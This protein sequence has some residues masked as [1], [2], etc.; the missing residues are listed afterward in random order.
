VGAWGTPAGNSISRVDLGPL[1]RLPP[2][3]LNPQ[4]IGIS[5]FP[6]HIDLQWQPAQDDPNG[7]GAAFYNIYRNGAFYINITS[8]NFSDTAV[9]P[10]TS[11]TY[12][13]YVADYH[14]NWSG[15][16][17]TFTV[18]TPPAGAIDPRRAGV[19]PT[20][21]YW[22]AA[23]ENIDMRSGNLNYTA[24]LLKAMGRGGWGVTFALN[25]NSQLWRQDSGGT[26]KLGRDL[27]YGFGWR[28]QAGSITPFWTD[29]SVHHYIFIDS[30]GAECRLNVNTN[31][32]WSSR[33]GIYLEYDPATN[34]LYFPDGS[35]WVMGAI[36]AGTEEDAGAR[37]P[38][39]MQD[40][41]GNQI[42]IRYHPGLG[43]TWADSSARI[44]EIEDVRAVSDGAGGWRTYKFTYNTDPIPHL[45]QIGN[46]IG[47]SE[48][49]TFSYS[50]TQTLY[51][52]FSPPTAFGVTQWLQSMA[53]PHGTHNF[54]PPCRWGLPCAG[55]T[56]RSP[57]WATA[58]CARCST[59]S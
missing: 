19:R 20:G 51:S 38:S 33:E 39:L 10:S 15:T 24:P 50:A 40:T 47:T 9:S 30:T 49:Y 5:E 21:S 46:Y 54:A 12:T 59:A 36:S 31:G 13:I 2:Y 45:T 57:T 42:L 6:E 53:G 25:Y 58:P 27:G 41:N 7:V 55:P 44:N 37:Y 28:L 48:S 4:T 29:W 26:W 32:I 1:D 16:P 34:K 8:T 52:P 18:V 23:G 22:G 3:P 35:F 56:G 43:V 17:T 11:Y 14:W